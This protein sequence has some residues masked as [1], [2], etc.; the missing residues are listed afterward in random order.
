LRARLQPDR[1]ADRAHLEEALEL[2]ET[3]LAVRILEELTEGGRRVDVGEVDGELARPLRAGEEGAGERDRRRQRLRADEREHPRAP[4]RRHDAGQPGA[5][6]RERE[7]LQRADREPPLGVPA[8]VDGPQREREAQEDEPRAEQRRH[9][10]DRH[11]LQ[12]EVVD[13][14]RR[15]QAVVG[16]RDDELEEEDDVGEEVGGEDEEEGGAP[17]RAGRH[18]LALSLRDIYPFAGRKS[19]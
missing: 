10:L 12:V 2:L 5:L 16:G 18:G 17:H 4:P 13:R 15:R 3:R 7:Q 11:K 8:L 19:R 1:A 9:Q 6:G 14:L